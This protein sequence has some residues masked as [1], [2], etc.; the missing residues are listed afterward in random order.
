M[1]DTVIY[2]I[3]IQRLIG[4][5]EHFVRI[6]F[7][8]TYLQQTLIAKES[9]LMSSREEGTFYF[10]SCKQFTKVIC[11]SVYVAILS[12]I[13]CLPLCNE[14]GSVMVQEFSTLC[15]DIVSKEIIR[16]D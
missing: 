6:C 7:A 12:R 15:A 1:L 14:M 3:R 13:T 9:E 2:Y 11:C 4:K 10:L 5:C 8:R 16:R